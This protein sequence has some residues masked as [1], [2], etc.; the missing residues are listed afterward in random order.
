MPTA[1]IGSMRNA[2]WRNALLKA[3]L[4]ISGFCLDRCIGA[5]VTQPTLNAMH[6]AVRV[7][8][9]TCSPGN[10]VDRR[11]KPAITAASP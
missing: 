7:R 1:S 9:T 10:S 2:P 5:V 3:L 4:S 11:L 8:A 6:M